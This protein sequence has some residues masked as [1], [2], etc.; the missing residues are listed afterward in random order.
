[1]SSTLSSSSTYD[2]V[3]AAYQDNASYREDGSR[4]KALAFITA[5]IFLADLTPMIAS[6]DGQS[7]TKES[8]LEQQHKAEDWL[9]A[10]PG[11]SG[12]GSTRVRFGD[13]QRSRD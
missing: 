2:E 3:K 1:M 9:V 8:L 7:T 12:S 5:C 4:T 11:S 10:N 6:R 13:F